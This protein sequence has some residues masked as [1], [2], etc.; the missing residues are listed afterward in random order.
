MAVQSQVTD[1]QP[2]LG[3]NF[4]ETSCS[5][6][7]L[8]LRAIYLRIL[9]SGTGAHLAKADPDSP[10]LA[11]GSAQL[12]ERPGRILGYV[13]EKA[14][15]PRSRV[16]WRPAKMSLL[17]ALCTSFSR[18]LGRWPLPDTQVS[19]ARVVASSREHTAGV[20]ADVP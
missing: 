19:T 18:G 15:G 14:G 20:C 3:L 4:C 9:L 8:G 6:V 2:C 16:A 11:G 12:G 17:I 5:A 13:W 10:A 7:E 1:R